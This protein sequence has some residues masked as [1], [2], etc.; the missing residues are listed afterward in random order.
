MGGQAS[1]VTGHRTLLALAFEPLREL[2]ESVLP[3]E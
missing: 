3:G 1:I 2:G